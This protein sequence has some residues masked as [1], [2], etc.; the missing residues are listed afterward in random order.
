MLAKDG[1]IDDEK[2]LVFTPEHKF[3]VEKSNWW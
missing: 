3:V 2:L 1:T